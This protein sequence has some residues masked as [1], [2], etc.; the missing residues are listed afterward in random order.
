MLVLDLCV[1]PHEVDR[2]RALGARWNTERQRWQVAREP[3]I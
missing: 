2:A 3:S 1:P